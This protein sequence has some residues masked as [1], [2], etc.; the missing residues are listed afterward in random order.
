[1]MARHT[2]LPRFRLDTDSI[3]E[4]NNLGVRAT[5]ASP[6]MSQPH[7]NQRS[8]NRIRRSAC[9]DLQNTT[10]PEERIYHGNRRRASLFVGRPSQLTTDISNTSTDNSNSSE[11]DY[12][13]LCRQRCQSLYKSLAKKTSSTP[14]SSAEESL[15]LSDED[16]VYEPNFQPPARTNY[17]YSLPDASPAALAL[18]NI[19]K[20]NKTTKYNHLRFGL[21]SNLSHSLSSSTNSSSPISTFR[22]FL[23]L[24]KLP[25]TKSNNSSTSHHSSLTTLSNA[26]GGSITTLDQTTSSVSPHMQWHFE[27][28]THTPYISTRLLITETTVTS[29]ISYLYD[30]YIS[31]QKKQ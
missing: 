25:S 21:P 2:P 9:S 27:V 19:L 11:S 5:S 29:R 6:N 22:N 10:I 13:K 17:R 31:T 18:K 15:K 14:I 28:S 16:D 3:S 7:L 20:R 26:T 8:Q 4:R 1:M 23:S 30:I 24:V 12:I